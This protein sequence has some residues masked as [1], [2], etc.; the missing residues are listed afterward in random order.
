MRAQ[1][2][3]MIGSIACILLIGGLGAWWFTRVHREAANV[4]AGVVEFKKGN[5]A[6]AARRLAP[7]AQRGNKTARLTLGIMYAFGN[8]VAKDRKRATELLDDSEKAAD[9]YFWIGQ[10]F[11]NGDGVAEDRGEAK[12]WYSLA[13]QAGN[14]EAKKITSP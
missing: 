3:K 5:Y 6:D 10:S 11:D 12:V 1:Q 13:A 8:G 7:Y 2:Q 14:E 9:L 4:D